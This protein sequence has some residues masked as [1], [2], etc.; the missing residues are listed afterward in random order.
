MEA[1]WLHV[2]RGMLELSKGSPRHQNIVMLPLAYSSSNIDLLSL[3]PATPFRD[4]Y[5]VGEVLECSRVPL[6]ECLLEIPDLC[7]PYS[8][9]KYVT[10][11]RL[12]THNLT[13]IEAG[14]QRSSNASKWNLLQPQS[15]S[16]QKPCQ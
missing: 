8:N 7:I 10:H 9:G 14:F 3:S 1:N 11:R 13:P 2:V 5:V 6:L 16:E 4:S 12:C 15:S